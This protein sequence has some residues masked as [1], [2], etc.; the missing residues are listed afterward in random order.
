M[1]VVPGV[2]WVEG[3]GGRVGVRAPPFEMSTLL[4]LLLFSRMRRIAS[5]RTRRAG[6]SKC[7]SGELGFF[8]GNCRGATTKRVDK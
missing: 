6:R 4:P 3:E 7:L 5:P 1:V 2:G 8:P